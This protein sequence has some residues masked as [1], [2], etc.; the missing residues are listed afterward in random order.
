LR[1]KNL[2]RVVAIVG[3][4]PHLGALASGLIAKTPAT[5]AFVLRKSSLLALERGPGRGR[6]VARWMVRWQV[7]PELLT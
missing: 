5:S 2:R 1:V 7:S 3:H 6:D 4:E